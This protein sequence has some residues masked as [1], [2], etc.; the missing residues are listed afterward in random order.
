MESPRDELQLLAG[1]TPRVT[2]IVTSFDAWLF[3]DSDVL[4]ALLVSQIFKQVSKL[5]RTRD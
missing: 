3:A 2:C 4:W 5:K 1:T